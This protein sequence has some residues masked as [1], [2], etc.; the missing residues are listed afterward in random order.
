MKIVVDNTCHSY[1]NGNSNNSKIK[2]FSFCSYTELFFSVVQV[3]KKT[4]SSFLS[5]SVIARKCQCKIPGVKKK[6][7]FCKVAPEENSHNN[8]YKVNLVMFHI[9]LTFLCRIFVYSIYLIVLHQC[10]LYN[11]CI[12][13][14]LYTFI[15]F[16]SPI[17]K[18]FYSAN[19][20]QLNSHRKL[21]IRTRL[22]ISE[23]EAREILHCVM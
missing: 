13:C 17:L 7:G 2:R 22:L 1:E 20:L 19:W 11:I 23:Y 3:K 6:I 14:C 15:I 12:L 4:D 5:S 10:R 21:Q 18:Y 9:Y 16:I 8:T